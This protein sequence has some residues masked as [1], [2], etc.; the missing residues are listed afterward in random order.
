MYIEIQDSTVFILEKT[1]KLKPYQFSQ[2][3]SIW[4]FKKDFNKNLFYVNSTNVDEIILKI[5]NYF[6]KEK[7]QYDFSDDVKKRLINIEKTI[8]EFQIIKE[9]G[10]KF[11]DSKYN[12]DDFNIFCKFINNNIKRKLKDHQ[13][14]AAYH[15]NII[16]NAANFSV[17]GSGKT[18]VVLCVY[19]KLRL[20][21]QVN[22]IF[23]VGPYS[24]FGPWK[25]EFYLTLNRK[26]T[27]CILA[28][29]VKAYRKSEYFNTLDNIDELYLTTYQT[30]YNDQDEIIKFFKNKEIKPFLI[31]DEAHYIKQLDG[32]WAKAALRIANYSK[33]RCV[34]TGTPMPKSYSD[35]F[36]I[37]DFLWPENDPISKVDKIK[38][39]HK[40][41]NIGVIKIK[42][43]LDES[44][45]P[46]FYRVRKKDLGLLDPE[47]HPP[48]ILEMNKYERMIYDIIEK[49]IKDL[50]PEDYMSNIQIIDKLKKG[51]IIRLRQ[52]LSYIKL[53]ITAVEGYEEG[54]LG[55]NS[56]I[57]RIIADYEK[58]EYPAKLEY[59]LK[60]ITNLRK[61]N[62]KVLIWSNF[63]ETLKLI[64]RYLKKNNF[65]SKLIYGQ[66][67]TEK[68]TLLIEET[69]E[70][71][72]K[73]F[74]NKNSGLDIL[75]ANPAAC[76]ESISLHKTCFH[77]IYYDL[78]YNCAQYL[79]SL[80]RIHRVGGSEFYKAN[81]YFLQYKDTIEQDIKNNLDEKA[82]RM[83]ALFEK[84]FSIYSL[85]MFEDIDEDIQAYERLFINK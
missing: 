66:I 83:Y 1:T 35:V 24:C 6:N 23:V 80:D 43:I 78:S 20:E 64:Q 56:D 25:T 31:I 9:L 49:K 51:R 17:P 7:I 22:L 3:C 15:L 5:T 10:K 21:K 57:Y 82:K 40:N 27:F 55:Y 8:N 37:F 79:Q 61:K 48:I 81:Y 63:I 52:A 59:L 84:D 75:I 74:I 28:G 13:Y 68:A 29:G 54:L 12:K 19:E 4:G 71:I 46:L 14:K 18:S 53:L 26:P 73:E 38:I 2:L 42:N 85:D 41:R 69:R 44:I 16:K 32:L 33:F 45:S 70:Q 30:F 47:F 65:Y 34:L 11:K 39:L 77:A 36:N 67:P 72:I 76:S 60:L 62:L 58:I 50:L